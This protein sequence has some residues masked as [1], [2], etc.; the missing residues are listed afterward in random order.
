MRHRE[1][2]A[3]L[4]DARQAG[5]TPYLNAHGEIRLALPHQH[6]ICDPINAVCGMKTG[7]IYAHPLT[8]ATKL[9]MTRS[10]YEDIMEASRNALL[11]LPSTR[12]NLLEAL[13]LQEPPH[14]F[15][16][17]LHRL[18]KKALMLRDKPS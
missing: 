8:A 1:F 3:C 6:G 4:A 5:F 9:G 11:L 2:F 15:R 13:G 12:K 14:R 17:R 16:Q 7:I 10:L 18:L